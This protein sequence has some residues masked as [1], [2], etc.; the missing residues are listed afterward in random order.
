MFGPLSR[1]EKKMRGGAWAK[2]HQGRM[3]NRAGSEAENLMNEY[4]NMPDLQIPV[5]PRLAVLV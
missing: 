2:R 4:L 1:S 5:R 3:R